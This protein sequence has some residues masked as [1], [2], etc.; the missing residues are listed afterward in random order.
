TIVGIRAANSIVELSQAATASGTVTVS[1][2]PG[3]TGSI[4]SYASPTSVTLSV[5]AQTSVTGGTYGGGLTYGSDDSAAV[6][7]AAAAAVSFG[8]GAKI[9]L[10]SGSIYCQG[11]GA[12]ALVGI[13]VV[14]AGPGSLGFGSV[15]IG[16]PGF[17]G[18]MVTLGK[19][20]SVRD[21]GVEAGARGIVITD[22]YARI[23]NVEVGGQSGDGVVFTTAQSV[24]ASLRDLHVNNCGGNGVNISFATAYDNDLVG[25]TIGQCGANGLRIASSDI[26]CTNLH[27]WGNGTAGVAG[28]QNGVRFIAGVAGNRF[29]NCYFESNYGRGVYASSSGCKGHTFVGC[30]FWRNIQQGIYYFTGSFH[31][32]NGCAFWDQGASTSGGAAAIANDTGNSWVVQG[33]VFYDDQGTKTQ[34]Y[35]YQEIGTTSANTITGNNM[36]AANL[37]TASSLITST[38]NIPVSASMGTLNNV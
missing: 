3:I 35:A 1:F 11:L 34:T 2:S 25:V 16:K 6:T 18:D 7:A 22:A 28:D 17:A 30:W 13:S 12:T 15:L 24:G 27:S 20:G 31:S 32:I 19:W 5:S 10:P 14:G 9:T 33:N 4:A 8:A 26:A 36:Q 38:T 29:V 37:K 23:Q 21:C